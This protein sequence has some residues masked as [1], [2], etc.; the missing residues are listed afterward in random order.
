VP[1]RPA[2]VSRLP[3]WLVRSW[4]W[5][6]LTQVPGFS[7]P[8]ILY[9]GWRCTH[10]PSS[11][12]A[13]TA[14]S[15]YPMLEWVQCSLRVLTRA[16]LALNSQVFPCPDIKG[17]SSGT[18]NSGR[19]RSDPTHQHRHSGGHFAAAVQAMDCETHSPQVS[20]PSAPAMAL[21]ALALLDAS[22]DD[23]VCVLFS[24]GVWYPHCLGN[25]NS[26]PC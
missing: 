1:Q 13:L 22:Q 26:T 15:L 7:Q 11:A 6:S 5:H 20:V 21:L 19:A 12:P 23:H 9:R 4:D 3:A 2:V 25:K 14:Y 17:G 8:R 18:S 16:K 24:K 10:S